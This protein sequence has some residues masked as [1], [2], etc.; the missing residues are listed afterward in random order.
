MQI[1]PLRA[2]SAHRTALS[3]LLIDCVQGGASLGFVAPLALECARRYWDGVEAELEQGSRLLLIATDGTDVAGSV[4]LSLCMKQ[5][6]RHRAE[7]EKL[8]VRTARR[9]AGTGRALMHAVEALA[10]EYGRS[11]LVL[12][13]RS[14]D[15]ASMLYRQCG[16]REA[17]RIPNF[18]L[19]SN[20]RLDSTTFF[21]KEV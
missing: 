7:V 18:A 15:V 21:Y 14:D 4:Q 11:L 6:G 13:T 2:L 19:S 1:E 5:N 9:R 10:K 12:D 16:Y 3:L 8:L 17:G 20:G